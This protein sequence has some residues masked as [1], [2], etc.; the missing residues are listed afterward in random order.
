MPRSRERYKSKISSTTEQRICFEWIL[1]FHP[2][3]FISHLLLLYIS[4]SLSY[5]IYIV[6]VLFQCWLSTTVNTISKIVCYCFFCDYYLLHWFFHPKVFDGGL[7]TTQG[8]HWWVNAGSERFILKGYS[9]ALIHVARGGL[10]NS[11]DSSFSLR[12]NKWGWPPSSWQR[13]FW[14]LYSSS[15]QP[16]ALAHICGN[17]SILWRKLGVLDFSDRALLWI[18]WYCRKS[19]AIFGVV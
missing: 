13:I 15:T 12:S 14:W 9:W 19:K 16:F 6:L 17:G 11:K 5:A 3:H 10:K 8:D 18:L 2:L 4:I 7:T 1:N